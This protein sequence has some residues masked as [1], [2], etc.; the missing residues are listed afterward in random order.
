MVIQDRSL[1]ILLVEDNLGDIRILTEAL[2]EVGWTGQVEVVRDGSEALEYLRRQ[3]RH[4]NARRP[5]LVLLDLNLPRMDGLEVLAQIKPDSSLR[6]IPVVMLSSSDND[7]D[8]TTAYELHAN[9]Y[10]VKPPDFNGLV[11]AL[12]SILEYWGATVRRSAEAW[13]ALGGVS[14]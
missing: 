6:P 4:K 7:Q 11:R 9:S 5:D 1:E 12:R 2:K 8:V 13:P 14:R 10:V 3:G